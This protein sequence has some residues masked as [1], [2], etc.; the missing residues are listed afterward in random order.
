M[1]V[2]LSAIATLMLAGCSTSAVEHDFGN[3]MRSLQNAQAANP[4]AV[5]EPSAAAVT[6]VEPDYADNVLK[7]LRENVSKPEDVKKD[8][9][10]NVSGKK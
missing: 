9:V 1:R 5:A 7:E 8:V 10:I 2:K 4:K 3:S 6:G